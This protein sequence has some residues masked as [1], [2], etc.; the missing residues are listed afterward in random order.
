MPTDLHWS[1][2]NLGI[3]STSPTTKLDVAGTVQAAAFSATATT[4]ATNLNADLLDGQHG[5]YYQNATNI[6]TG[7]LSVSTGGTGNTSLTSGKV[8]VGN[9]TGAITTPTNLHWNGANL[10]IGNAT[11]G[12]TLDV[13]GTVR[14]TAV[15][16]INGTSTG[17]EVNGGAN[18]NTAF[19]ATSSGAG[20]GS[21]IIYEN[22]AGGA[23]SYGMYSASTGDFQMVDLTVE[24]NRIVFKST[25]PI[26]FPYS[27]LGVYYSISGNTAFNSGRYWRQWVGNDNNPGGNLNYQYFNGSTLAAKGYIENDDGK[28]ENI[29]NF[30]GQHRCVYNSNI[31]ASNHL[32]MI[33]VADGTYKGLISNVTDCNI[34]Q[35]TINESLPRVVI[36]S[37]AYQQ[38][39]LGV[40]SGSLADDLTTDGKMKFGVG[41]VACI[42]PPE[43]D[44]DRLYINSLGEGAIWVCNR[45]GNFVNGDL[46]TTSDIPGYG[47]VQMNGKVIDPQNGTKDDVIRSYTVGKITCAV[48]FD[49]PDL[50]SMFQVRT[51]EGGH[52]A[53]FAGCVYKAG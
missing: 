2:A 13:T 37:Y 12:T 36:S 3:G 38:N 25:G 10:G 1:G 40:V 48:D 11:P 47:M 18:N 31:S 9:G 26:F 30:T 42:Q 50:S 21:G 53:V 33:V 27:E 4:L 41:F 44:P 45:N 35:I 17:V 46:I 22:T 19:K 43:N 16:V 23:R 28:A 24:Q 34:D 20:W 7:T 15:R 32:G 14:S 5:S 39:C 49:R 8:L 51:L 29:M 6:N 52:I